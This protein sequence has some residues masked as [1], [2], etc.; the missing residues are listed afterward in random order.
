MVPGDYQL[1][2]QMREF[3]IIVRLANGKVTNAMCNGSTYCFSN[4]VHPT[5]LLQEWCFA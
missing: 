4:G 3:L 1:L 5:A 2:R